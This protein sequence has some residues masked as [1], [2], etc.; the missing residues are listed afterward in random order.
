MYLFIL[1]VCGIFISGEGFS[2]R[3]ADDA[4]WP[5]RVSATKALEALI[6]PV[7]NAQTLEALVAPAFEG[8]PPEVLAQE[9]RALQ[10]L[11]DGGLAF[12]AVEN[13]K[14]VPVPKTPHQEALLT[15]GKVSVQALSARPLVSGNE[16]AQN[17]LI[18]GLIDQV[19]ATQ[20]N[21]RQIGSSLIEIAPD[22]EL[23]ALRAL[24]DDATE[25][26]IQIKAY[27][28]LLCII[29]LEG[30]DLDRARIARTLVALVAQNR[31]TKALKR[32]AL[33]LERTALEAQG[34]G[35]LFDDPSPAHRDL[36]QEAD[37]H[38]ILFDR[39]MSTRCLFRSGVQNVLGCV[40]DAQNARAQ[41]ARAYEARI[42]LY[43]QGQGALHQQA[44]HLGVPF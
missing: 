43:Q 41:E 29:P 14:R 16:R 9:V 23:P 39:A 28:T 10:A 6:N 18:K 38:K 35:N 2:D 30:E 17:I 15:G 19:I 22:Q 40:T 34:M 42:A 7:P 3:R 20:K 4:R 33:A 1:L 11:V 37:L 44:L 36:I 27:Q 31:E 32:Q 8:Q 5:E 21:N 26:E 25:D 24:V 13:L 12:M